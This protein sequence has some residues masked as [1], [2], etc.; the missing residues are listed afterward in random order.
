MSDNNTNDVNP[1]VIPVEDRSYY[2]GFVILSEQEYQQLYQDGSITK[3][4]KT[5]NYDE[6]TTY[7]TPEQEIESGIIYTQSDSDIAQHVSAG[8]V[9]NGTVIMCSEKITD[10][11]YQLGHF[12]ALSNVTG[13]WIA[14]DITAISSVTKL[15]D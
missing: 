4:G 2:H 15:I 5:I 14:T 3:N 6:N 10:N 11:E 13:S 9:A 7:S 1:T 8:D 12:Y